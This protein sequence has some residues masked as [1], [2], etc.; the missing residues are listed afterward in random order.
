MKTCSRCKQ[1]KSLDDFHRSSRRPDGRAGW[2][3]AC[4]KKYHSD[5]YQQHK[6]VLDEQHGAYVQANRDAVVAYR[7]EWNRNAYINSVRK[8]LGSKLRAGLKRRPSKNAPSIDD[9][10]AMYEAQE[11]KCALTGIVMTRLGGR[12]MQTSI[13][14]DRIDSKKGYSKDNI[15]LICHAVNAF[16]GPWTDDMMFD[17]AEA[18]LRRNRP[19]ALAKSKRGT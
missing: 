17:M 11:G 2:C 10:V 1:E 15:R 14:L 8:Q 16:K 13:S 4:E 19:H 5:Y 12:I 9:L 3:K 18:L 7:S 6:A